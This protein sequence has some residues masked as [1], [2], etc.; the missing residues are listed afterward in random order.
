MHFISPNMTEIFLFM[1]FM[2]YNRDVEK[3]FK[4]LVGRGHFVQQVKIGVLESTNEEAD[5][6]LRDFWNHN[7]SRL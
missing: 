3:V 6:N 1:Q 7:T 2:H 4:Y 5:Q